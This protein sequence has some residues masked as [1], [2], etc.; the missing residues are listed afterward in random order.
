M[1]FN[2]PGKTAAYMCTH[3]CSQS[4]MCSVLRLLIYHRDSRHNLRSAL[5]VYMAELYNISME[6]PI[7]LRITNN[8]NTSAKPGFSMPPEVSSD[9]YSA[10]S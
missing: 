2:H 6:R 8:I 9:V 1:K 7:S 5:L 4:R 10:R 3:A